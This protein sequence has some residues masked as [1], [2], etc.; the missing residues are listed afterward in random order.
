MLK[1]CCKRYTV[2]VTI[3]FCDCGLMWICY[4]LLTVPNFMLTSE[5]NYMP[6]DHN[7]LDFKF[8]CKY[9]DT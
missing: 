9:H 8:S 7:W 5:S 1:I 6:T 4:D 2:T 3:F